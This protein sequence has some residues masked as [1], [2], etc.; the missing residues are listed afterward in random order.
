MMVDTEEPKEEGPVVMKDIPNVVPPA[1]LTKEEIFKQTRDTT[2]GLK[3]F[4]HS[5]GIDVSL[6]FKPPKDHLLRALNKDEIDQPNV[7]QTSTKSS[8]K[9]ST[10]NTAKVSGQTS[11]KVTRQNSTKGSAQATQSDISKVPSTSSTPKNNE[12]EK[13]PSV[14]P[15]PHVAAPPKVP[16]VPPSPVATAPPKVPSVPPSPVATAPPKVP[17]T[18]SSPKES[19]PSKVTIAELLSSSQERKV[20][21][22]VG[23][24]TPKK[25]VSAKTP[26][27]SFPPKKENNNF[28]PPTL[29]TQ[30]P[31]FSSESSEDNGPEI[32]GAQTENFAPPTV[33][34][35]E[36]GPEI[37]GPETENFEP[38]Q[39]EDNGPPIPNSGPYYEEP[40]YE[41]QEIVEL[42]LEFH[43]EIENL[44]FQDDQ[45]HTDF[46]RLICQYCRGRSYFDEDDAVQRN[47]RRLIENFIRKHQPQLDNEE[48][49][50][51]LRTFNFETN[52]LHFPDDDARRSFE[53]IL[54]NYTK[55]RTPEDTD[56]GLQ[57]ADR[58]H[59]E[60][61]IQYGGIPPQAGPL[62]SGAISALLR[63]GP[64]LLPPSPPH[65]LS[66]PPKR[67]P[68][69]P[70]KRS[71]APKRSSPRR[72]RD[73]NGGTSS[74]DEIY[75]NRQHC[76]SSPP[77]QSKPVQRSSPPPNRRPPPIPSDE[78]GK[79]NIADYPPV[80]VVRNILKAHYHDYDDNE[81]WKEMWQEYLQKVL[82]NLVSYVRFMT[83]VTEE[84]DYKKNWRRTTNK[85][86]AETDDQFLK[87]SL[88]LVGFQFGQSIKSNEQCLFMDA[89]EFKTNYE[90][91]VHDVHFVLKTTRN[92]LELKFPQLDDISEEDILT[93]VHNLGTK[94]PPPPPPPPPQNE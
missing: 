46:N 51:L 29:K 9:S 82:N 77:R 11:T 19:D 89:R 41:E 14:P 12:P 42:S 48:Q 69:P 20:K 54:R 94:A 30:K 50:R 59:I 93:Q 55:G 33:Q 7:P 68:S 18:S 76:R 49:E 16:S 70:Q 44:R 5:K 52:E 53:R 62:K 4:L 60:R 72:P 35:E 38:P 85:A 75:G 90:K 80:V 17:S 3:N 27:G 6:P 37:P 2:N 32:Q 78:F 57:R 23:R 91:A 65:K 79:I 47:L 58:K 73:E 15:S 24:K 64:P 84:G 31:K 86:V 66:P 39:N 56:N 1:P 10:T 81:L 34:Y 61:I 28:I 87:I 83:Q 92:P 21:K 22:S 63:Q 71:P 13:V 45:E 67:P 26:G 88:Q 43:F 74:D 8:A 40:D 36:N 25:T